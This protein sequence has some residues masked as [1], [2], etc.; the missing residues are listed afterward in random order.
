MTRIATKGS[1]LYL[2]DAASPETYT[3]IAQATSLGG[4]SQENP[5]IEVTDLDSTAKEYIAGLVDNGE[6]TAALNFDPATTTHQTLNTLLNSGATRNWYIKIPTSPAYYMT[7]SGFVRTFPKSAE[8]ESVWKADLTI[9]VSGTVTLTT[10][11]P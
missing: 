8:V 1:Q 9:R 6:I 10:V 3:K 11:Q 2:G 7:F 5:E 4:P